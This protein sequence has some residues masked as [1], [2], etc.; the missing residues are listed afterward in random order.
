ME[1][2]TGVLLLLTLATVACQSNSVPASQQAVIDEGYTDIVMGDMPLFG[3]SDSDEVLLSRKFTARNANGKTISGVA[4]C[5][6][7]KGCTIRHTR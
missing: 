1:K 2:K 6:L 4:C 7:L 3:C 5:G